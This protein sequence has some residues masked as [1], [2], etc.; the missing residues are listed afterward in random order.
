MN[1]T[2]TYNVNDIFTEIPDDPENLSM[3]LPEEIVEEMGLEEGDT[4]RILYGDQG[5]VIIEKVKYDEEGNAIPSS[6]TVDD[7]GE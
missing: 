5:T 4:L 1:K 7:N 3:N 6:A 2:W